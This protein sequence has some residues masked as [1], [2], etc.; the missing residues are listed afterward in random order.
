MGFIVQPTPAITVLEA[1]RL[2]YYALSLSNF[3]TSEIPEIIGNVEVGGS[4]YSFS[5]LEPIAGFSEVAP[6]AV[7]I[8]LVPKLDESIEARWTEDA[9]SWS[10]EKQGW[11]NS[12]PGQENQRYVFSATKIDDS[13]VSNK[14]ALIAEALDARLNNLV[15][16]V[17]SELAST[18]QE[19]ED[20]VASKAS[21]P[22][23]SGSGTFMDY[24]VGTYVFARTYLDFSP[25][26]VVMNQVFAVYGR[27][28]NATYPFLDVVY[29]VAASQPAEHSPVP[30]TWRCRGY[31]RQ[32]TGTSDPIVRIMLMQRTA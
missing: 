9:P 20:L 25:S 1:Q 2:G 6:G 15:D 3:A 8:K 14:V 21:L 12:I 32:T 4:L 10:G 11:Y 17:N 16:D 24:P 30:G 27:T 28:G 31:Y 7:W 26:T 23:N 19:V 22:S 13:Q 29:L 5:S 18:I